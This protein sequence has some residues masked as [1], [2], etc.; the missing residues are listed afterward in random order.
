MTVIKNEQLELAILKDVVNRFVHLN[1]STARR[2]VLIKYKNQ[3]AAEVLQNLVN[4]NIIRRKSSDAA[5]TDEE[6]LPA[7]AAFELCG[8]NQLL[9]EAKRASAVVLYTLQQMFV[10][11]PREGGYA[12]NV[13]KEHA[14]LVFPNQNFDDATLKLGLYLAKDMHALMGNRMNQPD[15]TEVEWFQIAETVANLPDPERAWDR[16]MT[17][18]RRSTVFTEAETQEEAQWEHIRR[19]GG[20]GQSEVFLVRSPARVTQREVS[21]RTIKT[22]LE[23][24]KVSELAEA[25]WTYVRPDAP[26]ELGAMKVFKIAKMRNNR[27][28]V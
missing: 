18:Y 28:N 22:A 13:L 2:A 3:P 10:G 14:A 7:A 26:E 19:L 25:T 1:Q 4:Q 20:G 23:H 12:F 21:L 9:E 27:W 15:Q 11:D 24:S 6:Y 8:D 5:T 16:A 17:G